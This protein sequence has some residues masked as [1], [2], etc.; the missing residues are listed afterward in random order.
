[1]Y[2]LIFDKYA[3]EFLD[4]YNTQVIEVQ[5]YMTPIDTTDSSYY[6]GQVLA[7][8]T[9]FAL[10]FVSNY[11]YLEDPNYLPMFSNEAMGDSC[12]MHNFA[13]PWYYKTGI[14]KNYF[15]CYDVPGVK[16]SCSDNRHTADETRG[17]VWNVIM[18]NLMFSDAQLQSKA[19]RELPSMALIMIDEILNELYKK[20]SLHWNVS[21]NE[22]DIKNMSSSI[23]AMKLIKGE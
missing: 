7:Y 8:S 13:S 16:C 23:P 12:Y 5:P 3:Q 6:I 9:K 21:A 15:E 19:Y 10:D 2:T 14:Y 1:M 22:N 20:K 18:C 11:K 17:N 4:K